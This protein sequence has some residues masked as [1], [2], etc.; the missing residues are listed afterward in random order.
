[1]NDAITIRVGRGNRY[2]DILDAAEFHARKCGSPTNALAE[3][4]RESAM[5]AEWLESK[6]TEAD[7][8]EP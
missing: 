3:M 4:A 1:M 8:R 6:A 2:R 5:Y 7:A